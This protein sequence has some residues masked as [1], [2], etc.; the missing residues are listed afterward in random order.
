M[1]GLVMVYVIIVICLVTEYWM[2]QG[3]IFFKSSLTGYEEEK[4][5]IEE[6][7]FLGNFFLYAH[8]F[9][10]HA[11]QNVAYYFPLKTN[12]S[13]VNS[14]M[15]TREIED[16]ISSQLEEEHMYSYLLIYMLYELS[17]GDDRISRLRKNIF[18]SCCSSMC[19]MS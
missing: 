13:L 9:Y 18:T 7:F 15:Q 1:H 14:K 17:K 16:R 12:F 8:I 10:S 6:F 5:Q 11:N 19:R 3:C 2:H 4:N